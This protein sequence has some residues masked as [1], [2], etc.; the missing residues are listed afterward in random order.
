MTRRDTPQWNPPAVQC[1]CNGPTARPT[2]IPLRIFSTF[3][4]EVRRLIGGTV[5]A[6]V[7]TWRCGRCGKVH[8]LTGQQLF[9]S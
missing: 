9:S 5:T 7:G 1:H 8:T 2:I 3:A 6:E 4:A